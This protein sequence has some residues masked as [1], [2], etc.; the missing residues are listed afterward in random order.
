MP[1]KNINAP[2]HV[3]DLNAPRNGVYMASQW[4]K[5]WKRIYLQVHQL[6]QLEHSWNKFVGMISF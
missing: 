5:N 4:E 6:E 1:L 3:R 2:L